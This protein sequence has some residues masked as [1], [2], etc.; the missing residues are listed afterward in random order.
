MKQILIV[1]GVIGAALLLM[2][3]LSRDGDEQRRRPPRPQEVVVN[4]LVI[5]K[6]NLP[7]RVRSWG[8]VRSQS[9]IELHSEVEG[10]VLAGDHPFLAGTRFDKGEVLLRVDERPT[11]LALGSA[12]SQ[13]LKA[14][15]G[16]LPELRFDSP[17]DAELLEEWIQAFR[18]D[19]PIRP[20]PEAGSPKSLLLQT[21]FDLPALWNTA[22][23]LE[24]TLEKHVIRA[25]FDCT[26]IRA[27]LRPGATARKGGAI[28]RLLDL[29]SLEVEA[30]VPGAELHFIRKGDRASIQ[31][32]GTG[33][34]L[35]GDVVRI[36]RQVDPGTRTVPVY[37]GLGNAESRLME[38]VFVEVRFSG[39]RLPGTVRLP[40]HVL[41]GDATVA[42]LE[43][44]RLARRTIKV[45]HM[46]EDSMLVGEG[47]ADGDTLVVDVL[48]GVSLGTRLRDARAAAGGSGGEDRP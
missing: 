11:R 34:T 15:A 37:V 35:T 20:L 25:P 21:R 43:G 46:E 4:T 1:V 33:E 18:M 22:R 7:V 13:L 31:V 9:D 5:Q 6:E 23:N 26:V 32:P 2:L 47:L 48:Q 16:A 38:G 30:E 40:G 17:Q 3:F 8:R 45:E 44:G 39:S 36:G 27:D 14:A 42:V 12:R 41:G 19:E 28:G 10:P 29:S 24:L